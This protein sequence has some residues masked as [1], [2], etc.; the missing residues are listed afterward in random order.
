MLIRYFHERKIT[1]NSR[2]VFTSIDWSWETTPT[3]CTRK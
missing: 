1:D 3:K 2:S